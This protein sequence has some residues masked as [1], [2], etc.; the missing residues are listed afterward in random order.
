HDAQ[1][2]PLPIP[3]H[4]FKGSS[5]GRLPSWIFW[6]TASASVFGTDA[7]HE[8]AEPT[9]GRLSARRDLGRRAIHREDRTFGTLLALQRADGAEFTRGVDPQQNRG[10][11]AA[12]RHPSPT[13]R[14][15]RN[16][17]SVCGLWR[18]DTE[19]GTSVR[20]G[21]RRR[22]SRASVPRQLLQHVGR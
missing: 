17:E 18:T 1:G 12:S 15:Q 21:V 3:A 16:R 5:T 6:R 19:F 13:S 20:T 22:S 9:R 8:V 14:R 10:W 4:T 11:Y 2:L 7:P